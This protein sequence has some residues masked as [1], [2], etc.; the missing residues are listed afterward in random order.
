MPPF[1]NL[2]D[3]LF[4]CNDKQFYIPETFPE[5]ICCCLQTCLLLIAIPLIDYNYYAYKVLFIALT[6]CE[7]HCARA[8]ARLLPTS[9]SPSI[10]VT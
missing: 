8:R 5:A 3:Y 4:T 6:A 10:I 9:P 1:K 7:L 2:Y